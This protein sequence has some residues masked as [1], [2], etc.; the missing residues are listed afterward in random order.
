M[1][2]RIYTILFKYVKLNHQSVLPRG[3]GAGLRPG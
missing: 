3:R 1:H 2:F